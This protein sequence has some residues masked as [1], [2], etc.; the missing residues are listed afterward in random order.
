MGEW[1][2]P[3]HIPHMDRPVRHFL[4]VCCLLLLCAC[5]T[6]ERHDARV[7]EAEPQIVPNYVQWREANEFIGV[8]SYGRAGILGINERVFVISAGSRHD[9]RVG[10]EAWGVFTS[11]CTEKTIDK[12][13]LRI[14]DTAPHQ[15]VAL[16]VFITTW[17]RFAEY[18]ET[19]FV[20]FATRE[21]KNTASTQVV[22]NDLFAVTCL[23]KTGILVVDA[24]PRIGSNTENGLQ[25]IRR[26][27]KRDSSV[28]TTGN[29]LELTGNNTWRERDIWAGAYAFL[30]GDEVF[31]N[32]DWDSV[33][34]R[35]KNIASLLER[36][37]E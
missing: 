15:S 26:Y 1:L 12:Y 7:P 35:E 6:S 36:T 29:T 17:P 4:P 32:F 23:R 11:S 19:S 31:V 2:H 25:A 16:V 5:S 21:R 33:E 22:L 37:Q 34:T 8:D 13:S 18:S 27:L 30:T 14:I 20:R 3:R 28:S 10:D 24:T 9:V